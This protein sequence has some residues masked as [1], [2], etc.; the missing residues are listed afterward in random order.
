MKV[1]N[2]TRVII[3]KEELAALEKA[4]DILDTISLCGAD[5]SDE[6]IEVSEG[7]GEVL[8]NVLVC[9]DDEEGAFVY[10]KED[11]VTDYQF[12]IDIEDEES[13]EKPE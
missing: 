3:S 9:D 12:N 5:I 10:F 4:R 7:L 13:E 8:D 1:V 2:L 6:A 11:E